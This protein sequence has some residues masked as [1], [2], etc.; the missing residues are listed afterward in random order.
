MVLLEVRGLTKAFGGLVAVGDV[1]F[2][3]NKG[4]ILGLIGPNGAGKT[5]LY[6]S[7]TGLFK[8]TSG[9]V[10]YKGEDITGLPIYKVAQR[11]VVRTF[12]LTELLEDM[13]TF[14]NVVVAH[15]IHSNEG[16]WEGIFNTVKVRRD[17]SNIE[18]S[19]IRILDLLEIS[20]SKDELAKNLPHGHKRALGVAMG[21][22]SQPELLLLDEPVTGMNPTEAVAFMNILKRIRDNLGITL[23]IVE[24]NIKVIMS[25]CDRIF[26]IKFGRK[27]AEGV[28]SEISQNKDVIEA[29]IGVE[30]ED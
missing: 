15:H 21:L 24:H 7:V 17:R 10:V 27:I 29:Y 3:V 8:P 25:I 26:V 5:T 18:Q 13:T 12:Q 4:E 14:E 19:A 11:G 16:I 2:T 23:M 6:N 22:A 28:P 9:K 30:E 20:E 1:D